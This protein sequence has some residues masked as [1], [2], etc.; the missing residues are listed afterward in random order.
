[1]KRLLSVV[2]ALV[3]SSAAWGSSQ[4]SSVVA[5]KGPAG[6]MPAELAVKW[7]QWVTNSPD[8][9]DPLAD[10]SGDYCGYGQK[11]DVFFLA[12][13]YSTEKVTRQCTVPAGKYLFFPVINMMM[14]D[15]PDGLSCQELQDDVKT[16]INTARDLE[17]EL[18]GD[19]I[20]GLDKLRLVSKDCFSIPGDND[21]Y[22][23]DGYWVLLKP[24]KPG[25]HIIHFK[26]RIGDDGETVEDFMQD[27]EYTII[28]K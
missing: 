22:A 24:L 15:G 16:A 7:W 10:E 3:L 6:E 21:H 25:Q 26:G 11:G 1:M 4:P 14:W 13:S 12:T 23:T 8:D 17:V 2:V 19:K 9:T 18:D 28:T 27:I 5:E 20:N